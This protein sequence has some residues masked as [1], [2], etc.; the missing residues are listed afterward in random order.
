MGLKESLAKL[1]MVSIKRGDVLFREG[2]PSNGAMFFLFEGQLDIYKGLDGK[3]V[4]LRSI[5]P[6]EFFGEM[7]IINNSPRAASILA[8]SEVAKLGVINRQTFGKM[9]QESP[10]FLFLLLKRIIERL[11]ETESKIR[12]TIKE[13]EAAGLPATPPPKEEESSGDSENDD[14]GSGDEEELP[15]LED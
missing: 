12:E 13:R 10:E 3:Q 6:G 8:V 9:S 11:F 5:L 14:E 1:T 7:A 4:K 15:D 2:V